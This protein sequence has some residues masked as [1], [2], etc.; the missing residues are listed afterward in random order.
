[1]NFEK[2]EIKLLLSY[3]Q[4]RILHWTHI[5]CGCLNGISSI[6]IAEDQPVAKVMKYMGMTIFRIYQKGTSK[7]RKQLWHLSALFTINKKRIYNSLVKSI[8]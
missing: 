4:A 2:L 7:K 1:M 5:I 3:Q 6:G 8:I